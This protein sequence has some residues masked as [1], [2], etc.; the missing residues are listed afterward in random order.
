MVLF[1]GFRHDDSEVKQNRKRNQRLGIVAVGF[2][3]MIALGFVIG[4]IGMASRWQSDLE[5]L[6]SEL[7]EVSIKVGRVWWEPFKGRILIGR[8]SIGNPEGFFKNEHAIEIEE[9]LIEIDLQSFFEKKIIVRNLE[10]KGLEIHY[11]RARL[12][13]NLEVIAKTIHSK[14][15]L[16]EQL[17]ERLRQG[18]E[19]D[20]VSAEGG[21]IH[22]SA[23]LLRGGVSLWLPSLHLS[24]LGQDEKGIP[25]VELVGKILHTLLDDSVAFSLWIEEHFDSKR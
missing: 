10:I 18:I 2:F 17:P 12:R 19:V 8:L 3:G 16:P 21:K 4:R 24:D 13:S 25:M 9:L 22:F 7:A 5:G 14:S 23:T 20:S 6:G 15:K 1:D 11:E